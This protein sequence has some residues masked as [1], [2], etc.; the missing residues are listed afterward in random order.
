MP[1]A[2]WRALVLGCLAVACAGVAGAQAPVARPVVLVGDAAPGGGTF[3][4]FSI[5]SLPIV[6]AVNS[7]GQ[8]AFFATLLRAPASE[9]FF[10]ATSNGV[11][12]IAVEGDP[13][14]GGGTLSGF[15]RHPIPA[16]N[17]AG[18]VAFAA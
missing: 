5:E 11:V 7:G 10:L 13:A 12:K 3:E 8:V 15:G 6:A 2:P 18:D 4:R 1:H 17:D 9:G 16:I 14:P